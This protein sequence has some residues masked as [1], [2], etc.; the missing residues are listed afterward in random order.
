MKQLLNVFLILGFF[1]LSAGAQITVIKDKKALAEIVYDE[2]ADS[3][4]IKAARL[5]QDY[6]A[7]MTGIK[8]SRGAFISQK[9]SQIYIGREFLKGTDKERLNSASMKDSFI[10]C[11][12]DGSFNI[13]G[14][15]PIADMYAVSTLLEEYLG[16]MKFT[17]NDEY[18]PKTSEIILPD[19]CKIY[20][21]AFPFRVPHFQGRNDKNFRE[22]HRI[23][24]F[25][26]WGMFV[27]TFHRLVTP[28]KYFEEHPEYFA[29]VSG[30]RLQDGQLCLSNKDLMRLLIENLRA[31]MK[32]KPHKTYW[33]VSQNDCYN[34][35]E[36]ENCSALYDKYGSISGAYIQMTNDIAREFPDK[37]I[38][39]LA[40]QFTRSAP[41]NIKP[42]ENVNIMF[43]SIECNRSMP[44]ADDPRSADFVKDMKDWSRLSNNIFAWDYVVQF[45]NYLTPFPNFH[46][47]QPNIRFFRDNNVNM[48][49]QQGS[50]GSWSDLSDVKQYLIAKLLWN[51]EADADSIVTHFINKYYGSAAPYIKKYYDLTHKHL[52][53][54]QAEQVLDIYGFPVFYYD[55]HLTQELL[56]QYQD[57]MDKA[58]KVVREDS[59][60]Y[61][62]VL[63]A[64]IPADFAYLDIGHNT[65]NELV[66]WTIK[67]DGRISIDPQMIQKLDRFVELCKITSV[68]RINERS[69]KPE[70]YRDFVL[71]KLDWQIKS[72]ILKNAEIKLLT[73]ASSKYPV[74]GAQA[75]N[76]KLLGGLDYRFNWLG[77]EDK[78]MIL[79]IDLKEPKEFSRVQMNFLKAVNSWVFLPENLKIEVSNDGKIFTEKV[80][81]K[82]DNS[83]RSYLVKSIPFILNFEKTKA[84]Y[85]KI[86][87]LSMKTCPEWHRGY[88]KPAWI[89]TDE[90]ILE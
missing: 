26:D 10:L 4:T 21:P 5:L 46:V 7:E 41:K 83:D 28:E 18:I 23:S 68:E 82:G 8:L 50:G 80:S 42:L 16:C 40:Y 38:S 64:R 17:V 2:S 74:G 30:R 60:Y 33:S 58:E 57:L 19:I 66:K 85:V 48:M 12:R 59:V 62:R 88:G 44:L 70:D 37:Q 27:H 24:S 67:K 72:N 35:C 79:E 29:L 36:C 75:L 39:T 22:W 20:K 76:D 87:A 32:K 84:R 69:L 25:N 89:F 15:T 63:R 34:Y 49:F 86:T 53:E 56:A 47:L 6:L 81:V 51:P 61:K 90:I 77:F 73:N 43:C 13:A 52:I 65:N 78:H 31:E 45:K 71:R 14:K 11:S 54:K 9:Y 3:L 55:A 1:V